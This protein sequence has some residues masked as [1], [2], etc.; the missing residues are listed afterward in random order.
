MSLL[1]RDYKENIAILVWSLRNGG[2]ERAAGLLSI[3][4]SDKYNVYLF[5]RDTENIV[6]D[7]SGT[8]IDIDMGDR[9]Y[10]EENVA[11]AKEKFNI[12]YSI[13]FL[14]D[15]NYIN[16]LTKG[17]DYVIL[18][19]RGVISY[20]AETL[21]ATQYHMYRYYNEA[22][23]IVAC[24]YGVEYEMVSV[25]GIKKEL[26]TSIYNFVQ[27]DKIRQMAR[28]GES[29]LNCEKKDIVWIGRLDEIKNIHRLLIQ[30]SILIKTNDNI[31]LLIIGSG[32]Q[33]EAIYK[34]IEELGIERDVIVMPNTKNPFTYLAH[35]EMCVLTSKSEGCP[36]VILEAM[37]LSV[38]VVSVDCLGGPRELLDDITDYSIVLTGIIR[39]KRGLLVENLKS[40]DDGSTHMFSDAM[41]MML[42]DRD[43]AKACRKAQKEYMNYYKNEKL[44]KQWMD[45]IQSCSQKVH[46]PFVQRLDPSK[47]TVIYGAGKLAKKAL[48]SCEM[49][50]VKPIS[51]IVSDKEGNPDK[52][53]EIPVVELEKLEGDRQYI[54]VLLGLGDCFHDEVIGKLIKSGFKDIRTVRYQGI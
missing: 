3:Y 24:S 38:P 14:D 53:G 50:G 2:A 39:G 16:V 43:Y 44:L 4:L 48:I 29:Q 33:E 37:S 19:G 28:Q 15:M 30:F 49:Q 47:R 18:S 20:C 5:L 32:D 11:R 35:A 51:F 12:K 41:E 21:Y 22:D 9:D 34:D 27:K 23:A 13:S 1:C 46:M 8:I 10:T 45:V 40:D 25:F 17:K 54:Q 6:Y 42:N 52:I 7:Y 36:N 31:R 26:I